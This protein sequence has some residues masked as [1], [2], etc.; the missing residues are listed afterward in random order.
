[1]SETA[2]GTQASPTAGRAPLRF[3]LGGLISLAGVMFVAAGCVLPYA[4]YCDVPTLRDCPYGTQRPSL[5][6]D[7]L[8]GDNWHAAEPLVA[9]G[10]VIV[11]VVLM[12][13]CRSTVE[14]AILVGMVVAVGG[15]TAAFF[16]G[17]L[18]A[19]GG[20]FVGDGAGALG[21]FL[22]CLGGVAA[23]TSLLSSARTPST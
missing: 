11:A 6:S 18:G 20:V 22:V 10:L 9:I 5:L 3:T 21:G 12:L 17:Y 1:M 14:R 19:W 23:A 7:S 2:L 4:S 13:L 16:I 8:G 15:L